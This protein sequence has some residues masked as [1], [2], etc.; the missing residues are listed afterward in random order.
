M[1]FDKHEKEAL[2]YALQDFRGQVYL[3]GSRL[4]DNRRGG[5]I[6]LLLIPDERVNSVKLSIDIQKRFFSR[7]EQ[8]LDVLVF[9]EDNIFCQ[10]VLKNAQR[11]DLKTV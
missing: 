5:D 10:E 3:Y 1:R 7:C 8:S 4:D 9:R 6:D 2:K 11:L